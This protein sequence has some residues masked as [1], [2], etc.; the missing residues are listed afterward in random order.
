MSFN[1]RYN[2][3]SRATDSA[4]I[5]LMKKDHV[6]FIVSFLADI[7]EDE[8]KVD[9][10][11][12][13]NELSASLDLARKYTS[14]VPTGE[15]REII[16][17]W[18][19]DGV[20]KEADGYLFKTE[21]LDKVVRFF[22]NVNRETNAAS[23][24]MLDAW[25]REVSELSSKLTNDPKARRN[26]LRILK[27][28]IDERKEE[29]KAIKDGNMNILSSAEKKEK[30]NA[31][32]KFGSEFMRD[33]SIVER[34]HREHHVEMRKKAIA[35][36]GN[37][38]TALTSRLDFQQELDKTPE[39]SSFQNFHAVVS[40]DALHDEVK[41]QIKKILSD[42]EISNEI[43]DKQKKDMMGFFSKSYSNAYRIYNERAKSTKTLADI[44][45]SQEFDDMSAIDE[46]LQELRQ[47]T[48]SLSGLDI[49][50]IRIDLEPVVYH[51]PLIKT[52]DPITNFHE[53]TEHV[54]EEVIVAPENTTLSDNAIKNLTAHQA[55]TVLKKITTV[56]R[57]ENKE[58][59]DSEIADIA[60]FSDGLEELLSTFKISGKI[61]CEI[62]NETEALI[63]GDQDRVLEAKIPIIKFSPDSFPEDYDKIYL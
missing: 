55:K 23:S 38:K 12:V 5:R 25:I 13:S 53:V 11:S 6:V 56:V 54:E 33:C 49:R 8:S 29:M 7:F 51:K 52:F 3:Y 63:F 31:I 42:P 43:N 45:K 59:R 21:D 19:T 58:M 44:M 9:R 34:R 37:R 32:A 36:Q 20:I 14:E 41:A 47:I 62:S 39:G 27:K 24:S 17:S 30:L 4:A 40:N 1:E 61:D 22:D 26:R 28:E 15:P 16:S 50:N 2:F 60:P 46:V 10:A 57:E 18:L 48:L 35:E